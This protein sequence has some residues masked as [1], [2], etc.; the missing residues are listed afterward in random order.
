MDRRRFLRSAGIGAVGAAAVAAPAG[1]YLVGRNNGEQQLS[2]DYTSSVKAGQRR[3]SVNVWWS[4]GGPNGPGDKVLGLTFDDG[5]TTQFSAQVLDILGRYDVHASFFL[6]GELVERHP[7]LARRM[8]DD[9]HEVANHTFDHYSAAIQSADEVRRTVERGA[10]AVATVS[11]ERPRWFRPVKGHVTG[12]LLAAATEMGHD[13]ALWSV[14]RDPGTSIADDDVDGVRT[15]YERDIHD[16][17]IVI[18]HDGIG[19]SAFELSGPDDQLVTQR[20]TEITALPDVIETYLADGFRFL[21][22]SEL[23]DQYGQVPA[24]D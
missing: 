5:P 16:G 24:G 8:I 2:G 9:G 12:A 4:V 3:G 13:V 10:D 21:T 23:I 7:D 19:R 17:A 22:L 14:S 18:F 11:G 15:S 20:R 1:A 6:I